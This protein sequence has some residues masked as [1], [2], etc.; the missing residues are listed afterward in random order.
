MLQCRTMKRKVL[1][2]ALILLPCSL[3]AAI[4]SHGQLPE[5]PAA[6]GDYVDIFTNPAAISFKDEDDSFLLAFSYSDVIG[7]NGKLDASNDI[8]LS[9]AGSHMAFTAGVSTYSDPNT[10]NSRTDIYSQTAFRVD[11]GY[12][13]W[14]IGFGARVSGGTRLVRRN[15]TINN[16]L[17][18]FINAYFCSFE[19]DYSTGAQYFNLG[20]GVLYKTDIF[21]IGVYD[22]KILTMNSTGTVVMSWSEFIGSFSGGMTFSIGRYNRYGDLRLLIPEISFSFT[23]FISS[24]STINAAAGLRIQLLPDTNVTFIGTITGI[25]DTVASGVFAPVS[26]GYTAVGIEME[27]GVLSIDATCQLPFEVFNG[28][29][30]LL[31][32]LTI[33]ARSLL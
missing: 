19:T 28:T 2:L 30:S 20:L 14:N 24:E 4:T 18:Y 29:S 10:S 23:N 16:L 13:F 17:D 22:D 21:S 15:L 7:F 8:V 11:F 12:E 27:I 9:F 32:P 3:M 25:R 31:L 5:N 1:L 26:S 33:T 6:A